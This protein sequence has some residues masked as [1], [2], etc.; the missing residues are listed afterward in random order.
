LLEQNPDNLEYYRG[1]LR[2]K[3]YDIC[4]LYCRTSTE[5]A[6]AYPPAKEVESEAVP[7][8]L[9]AL[10]AFAESYPKS[11]APRRLALDIAQGE[12][13]DQTPFMQDSDSR[14]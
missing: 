1:F 4:E 13:L 7:K 6:S 3:G 14:R 5:G 12:W 9:S 2:T 11:S 8:I 10:D